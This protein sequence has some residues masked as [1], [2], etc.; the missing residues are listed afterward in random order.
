MKFQRVIVILTFLFVPLLLLIMFTYLPFFKMVELSFYD[1]GSQYNYICAGVL[2]TMIPV[3]VIFYFCQ[4]YIYSGMTMGAV[5][6]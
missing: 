2:I 6:E 3:L 5:K 4:K 1:M